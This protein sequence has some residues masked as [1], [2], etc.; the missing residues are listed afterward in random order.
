MYLKVT[1]TAACDML[2]GVT[3]CDPST[4][5]PSTLPLNSID[6]VDREEYWVVDRVSCF[7]MTLTAVP[8]ELECF[9]TMD[10]HKILADVA[11]HNW[12][13]IPRYM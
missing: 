7:K 2:L 11:V 8:H 13:H 5:D 12:S 10:C 1:T 9:E 4:V 6:L 3:S